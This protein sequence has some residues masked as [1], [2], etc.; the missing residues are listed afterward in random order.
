MRK[1]RN[2]LF[3]TLLTAGA[4]L[5]TPRDVAAY[6]CERCYD[7]CELTGDCTACCR[8]D[9]GTVHYCGQICP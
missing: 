8:C 2:L 9:G 4:V 5:S 7:R 1:L 6:S 3:A